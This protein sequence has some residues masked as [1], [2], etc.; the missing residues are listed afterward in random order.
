M[1]REFLV[2]FLR[3]GLNK[4]K[5]AGLLLKK[6]IVQEK[7]IIHNGVVVKTIKKNMLAISIQLCTSVAN[8]TSSST[9]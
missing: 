2:L 4:S 9:L 1:L 5:D 7:P 3:M 6:K 8:V